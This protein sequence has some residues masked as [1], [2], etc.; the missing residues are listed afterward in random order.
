M[1]DVLGWRRVFGVM[2]PST[3]TVVQ[4]DFDDLRPPGVTNHIARIFT[5]DADAVSDDSFRAGIATIG[6]NVLDAVRSVVTCRPDHLIMGM[7][8]VTF[9]DGVAGAEAFI[10][11]VRDASGL[12]VTI[13]SHACAAALEAHG[14]VRRV[15][16]LSPYWP[17]MNAGVA[18]Y[19]GERGHTVVR[20]LALRCPSWTGIARVTPAE[21]R[22]ALLRLD[23]DDVDAIL[24]VGTNLSMLRLA[25]AAELFLGKPVIAI[26]AA[27]YWHALRSTGITDRVAGFGRLLEE[28]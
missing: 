11:Q 13:G 7:S 1:R 15:A 9:L 10:R 14:G 22:A 27:T 4:P 28:F 25:A 6:G 2:A 17:V 24:Q 3:N 19:L 23:G 16:V 12:D 20:D 26:N 5:P 18:R 8:A 21:C